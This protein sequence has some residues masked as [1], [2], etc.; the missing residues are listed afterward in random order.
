MTLRKLAFFPTPYPDECYYSIFCRYFARSGSLSHQRI[1]GELF[2]E[3]QG[4]TAFVFLPRRLE[5]V[6]TWIDKESGVTREM[7]ALQHSS[8]PYFSVSFTESVFENMEK[9]IQTGK[10]D[11]KLELQTI[12]KCTRSYWPEYL[13]Y[14]P[15]CARED[16]RKYGETY[17]HRLPQ[18]PGVEYCP[19]H[20]CRIE[21]SDIS[22]KEISAFFR[23]ASYALKSLPKKSAGRDPY[24]KKRLQLA[25]DTA[26]LLKHGHEMGGCHKIAQKYKELFMERGV[27]TAQGVLHRESIQEEFIRYHGEEFLKETL[28]DDE[29]H[30]LYWLQ[31]LNVS[32]SEH[33]RPLH[34]ILLMEYLRGSVEN[35]HLAIPDIEPYGNGPWPCVNKVCPCY[36]KDSARK[37]LVT[38]INGLT[39]GHFQCDYCGMKYQRSRPELEFEE[40]AGHVAILE[41]GSLWYNMLRDCVEV[42]KLPLYETVKVMRSTMTTVQRRADEIGLN[43]NMNRKGCI[44][45]EKD[46]A[47]IDPSQYYR[48]KVQEALEKQ[49]ELTAQELD[50]IV[51]GAYAW[52]HKN[53]F[54]WL[55]ARLVI[56]QEK[57]HWVEWEKQRLKSLKAAYDH[58]QRTGD[59]DRRITIGWLCSTAGLRE[60]EIKGRLHRFPSIRAFLEEV[61]EPKEV[62]LRR[63]ITA[64]AKE[65]SLVGEPLTLADIKNGMGLKPNTYKKYALYM[66]E[67]IQQ[68]NNASFEI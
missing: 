32:V 39:I 55:K 44:Y 36:G 35:F 61:V 6:E 52:F 28:P 17:W 18:F 31:F 3:K 27:T 9:A 15:V 48:Q 19:K 1:I 7:L 2:G 20:L 49:P 4:L 42:K 51:P 11:R 56:D 14:C 25:R 66:K 29:N 40:Y 38:Y 65:K 8:Y 58:I 16:L 13:R 53:D 45:R 33:L 23:P 10:A 43:L 5:L 46:F 68:L 37:V 34:H 12:R 67:L 63:R 26:W 54:Q 60:N 24:K 57:R 64:I 30:F 41:Y 21:N 62:W 47:S 59:P 50:E 22:L